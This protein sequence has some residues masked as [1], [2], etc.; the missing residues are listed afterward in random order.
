MTCKSYIFYSIIY[1]YFYLQLDESP[2]AS[3][4]QFQPLHQLPSWGGGAGPPFLTMIKNG[5]AHRLRAYIHIQNLLID[6]KF[7]IQKN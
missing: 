3:T 5:K 4:F 2:H 1:S 7:H 6:S